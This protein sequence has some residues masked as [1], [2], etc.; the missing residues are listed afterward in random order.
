MINSG[1]AKRYARAFFDIA[2]ED[3]LYEQYYD[4][5]SSFARI[6]KE[7]KNLKEFLANPVFGQAEKKAVVEAILQKIKMSEMT[8]NFLKLLVDK[9]RIG[10]LA[11]IAD[12]YR[13]LM[14]EVLKRV[15]VSVKTAYP[16]KEE[17]TA[18]IKKGLEQMTGK[19]TEVTI[20]EDRSLLGGIVI[21]VG[22]TLYDGS[23]KTQLNNI[24]NLLGEAV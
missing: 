7:D 6:V 19:Q 1:I 15:R 18:E 8:S 11:E 20:E 5:L 21:R 16:L 2:G 14:D 17:A 22:D 4:E 3:K 12:Y 13:E 23:I 24:R 10:M 9:K